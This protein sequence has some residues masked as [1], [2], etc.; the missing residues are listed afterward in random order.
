MIN[1]ETYHYLFCEHCKIYS[2]CCVHGC[3]PRDKHFIITHLN[4]KL[5]DPD[6]ILMR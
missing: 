6:M 1:L 2:T 4:P 3:S 5:F